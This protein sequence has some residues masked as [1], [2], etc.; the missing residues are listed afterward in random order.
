MT[1]PSPHQ[2]RYASLWLLALLVMAVAF[3][4]RTVNLN[5]YPISADEIRHLLRIYNIINGST[6]DGL[7]QN[8]WFWGYLVAQLGANGP[9][10]SWVGRYVNVLW[11]LVSTA[12][13]ISLGRMMHSWRAGV[14]AGLLYAVATMGIYHERR[15]IHDA[16]MT[17]TAMVAFL[18]MIRLARFNYSRRRELLFL[19]IMTAFLLL[20]RLTK[21]AM[22]GFFALPFVALIL[23]RLMPDGRIPT[24]ARLRERIDGHF[25]RVAAYGAVSV[26]IVVA[27]MEW[28]YRL[29]AAQGVSPRGSHTV[30]LGNTVLTQSWTLPTLVSRFGTDLLEIFFIHLTFWSLGVV[31]FVVVGIGWL[32]ASHKYRTALLLLAVP[33]L[34]YLIIPMMAVRPA[35]GVERLFPRY[36]VINGPALAVFVAIAILLT[37]ERFL[38]KQR[39]VQFMITSLVVFPTMAIGMAWMF[40]PIWLRDSLNLAELPYRSQIPW[41]GKSAFGR[42]A[43]STIAADWAANTDRTG[44]QPYTTLV[45]FSEMEYKAYLGPRTGP[46]IVLNPEDPSA[47]PFWVARSEKAFLI[48][49]E[50]GYRLPLAY[51]TEGLTLTVFSNESRSGRQ[52]LWRVDQLNGAQGDAVYTHQ[53]ASPESMAADYEALLPQ[54]SSQVLYTFPM[55]H[56]EFADGLTETEV[57]P[58]ILQRWPLDQ[59]MIEA[60]LFEMGTGGE[61]VGVI[62]VDEAATDAERTLQLALYTSNLYAYDDIYSGVLHY[63]GFVTGPTDPSLT[64]VEAGYEEVIALDRFAILDQ[65]IRAGDPIRFAYIW[66]TEESIRDDFTTFTHLLDENGNL[67]AQYDGQPGRGLFPTSSWERGQPIIDRFALQTAPDLQPGTYTV[68][69]GLYNPVSNVRLRVTDGSSENNAIAI[70]QIVVK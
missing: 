21:P 66:V 41:Y 59:D 30:S 25:W 34:V 13:V 1:V 3:T 65:E 7:D 20:S 26:V 39:T 33:A 43:A 5:N 54:V 49:D 55:N 67:V 46:V 6:F 38:N 14:L 28:I 29:A 15:G 63:I 12:T 11:A 9:E 47:L 61:R 16:Q 56:A 51:R 48:E 68:R 22:V 23:L 32:V 36:L 62:L 17:A 10:A 44:A 37:Y 60:A 31:V 18:F 50:Q 45:T 24:F 69:V 40:D 52:W 70:G 2:Q 64:P 42:D 35:F 8:K 4:L 27:V 53:A 58:L 19:V 57:R